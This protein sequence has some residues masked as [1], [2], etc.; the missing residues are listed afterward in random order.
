MHE[1]TFYLWNLK[2]ELSSLL[3]SL[4]LG[5]ERFITTV[6]YSRAASELSRLGYHKE[7][8]ALMLELKELQNGR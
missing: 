3:S 7:A 2:Q 5:L 8:K 6:G 4:W 1:S